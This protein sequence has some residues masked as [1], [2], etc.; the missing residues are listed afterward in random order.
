MTQDFRAGEALWSEWTGKPYSKN[1]EKLIF[2]TEDAVSLETPIVKQGLASALQRDGIVD[3]LAACFRLV[4]N[5]DTTTT[6]DYMGHAPGDP[7]LSMCNEYGET[8]EGE[9]VTDKKIATFVEMN[10]A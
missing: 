2:F 8:D 4:D 5:A 9:V 10:I 6:H 7:E 1:E 3:S